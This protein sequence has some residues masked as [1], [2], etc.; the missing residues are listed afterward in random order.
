LGPLQKIPE[1]MNKVTDFIKDPLGGVAGVVKEKASALWAG[2]KDLVG[3]Q[4]GG[5]VTK[6]TIAQVGEHGAEAI[7]PL[8]GRGLSMLSEVLSKAIDVSPLNIGKQAILANPLSSVLGEGVSRAAGGL[9]ATA[10][11][12]TGGGTTAADHGAL[13]QVIKDAIIEGF[14]QAAPAAGAGG[15]ISRNIELKIDRHVLARVMDDVFED[16]VGL[17]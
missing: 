9:K 5:I 16:K 11:A 3:L 2:A 17:K 6:P 12:V 7:I 13:A 10:A 14:K 15:K 1:V 4:E 8:E